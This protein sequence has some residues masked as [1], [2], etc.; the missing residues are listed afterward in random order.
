M[1]ASIASG[2][3]RLIPAVPVYDV[4]AG[5]HD[6]PLPVT[7]VALRRSEQALSPW[8]ACLCVFG[9]KTFWPFPHLS[10]P[11]F[12]LRASWAVRRSIDQ[13]DPRLA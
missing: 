8:K 13:F 5:R 4:G 12:L 10:S 6:E 2:S 1:L 7:A 11:G 9:Q 3:I